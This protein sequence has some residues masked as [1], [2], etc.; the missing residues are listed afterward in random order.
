MR[1]R[2][3]ASTVAP[4]FVV[5]MRRDHMHGAPPTAVGRCIILRAASRSMFRS[6]ASVEQRGD[7]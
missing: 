7:R 6:L 1:W 5:H 4:G 2:C 3:S